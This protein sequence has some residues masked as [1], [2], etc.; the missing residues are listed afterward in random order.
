MKPRIKPWTD[1]EKERL[2][3]FTADGATAARPA[4][5]LNRKIHS[6]QLQA[7]KL[8]VRFPTLT[9]QRKKMGG[10]RES[11]WRSL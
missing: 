5:A 11:R 6:V 4:A 10:A 3:K 7:A 1:E 2:K 9:E 8:G